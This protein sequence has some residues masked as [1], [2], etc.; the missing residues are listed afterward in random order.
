MRHYVTHD[1]GDQTLYHVPTDYR[2]HA[3]VVS[4]TPSYT[5]IDLRRHEDDAERVLV[6]VTST[7]V[8]SASQPLT[9]AAGPTQTDPQRITVGSTAAFSEG[10]SYLL[11]EGGQT[12]LVLV[13]GLDAGNGYVYT[14]SDI[15]RNWTTS[16]SLVGVEISATFPSAEASDDD[17]LDDGGGPYGVV[18]SYSIDGRAYTPI[19]DLYI[20]RWTD[21]PLCTVEDIVDAFPRLAPRLR[22]DP[23]LMEKAAAFASKQVRADIRLAGHAPENLYS[24]DLNLAAA[25][26]GV[27]MVLEWTQGN[28]ADADARLLDRFDQRK[29][30]ILR[31]A[32]NGRPAKRTTKVTET[33]ASAEPGGTSFDL[34]E[35]FTPT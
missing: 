28:D 11:S 32:M 9:S 7:A 21:T 10:H 35:L 22:S 24:E 25:M 4:G 33:D 3:S 13:R 16:A 12:E 18:W 15:R 6:D 17:A 29:D 19:E 34:S 5:I 26:W 20:R 8:D 31:S 2:V 1:G 14:D 27:I 30:A 23:G